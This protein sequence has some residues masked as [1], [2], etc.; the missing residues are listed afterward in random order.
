MASGKPTISTTIAGVPEVTV[1]EETGLLTKPGD[2]SDL[3]KAMCRLVDDKRLQEALSK[4]ARSFAV[5]KLNIN[6]V[7]AQIEASY[8][9]A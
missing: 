8:Q 2:V 9:R 4:N 5:S 1:H 7:A 6:D 3:S